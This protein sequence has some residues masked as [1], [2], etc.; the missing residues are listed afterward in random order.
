MRWVKEAWRR[1]TNEL[2]PRVADATPYERAYMRQ[3]RELL[4]ILINCQI[5]FHNSWTL[6][7]QDLAKIIE[8]RSY[9]HNTYGLFGTAPLCLL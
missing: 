9:L 5:D 1:L 3:I 8:W 2:T 7:F 6:V 4:P